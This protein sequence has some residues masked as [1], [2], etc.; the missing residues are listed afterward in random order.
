MI[1][2]LNFNPPQPPHNKGDLYVASLV[3]WGVNIYSVCEGEDIPLEWHEEEFPPEWQVNYMIG[4]HS[5]LD[6]MK[7][8]VEQHA[9]EHIDE[10]AN[11]GWRKH[12]HAGG[13][14]EDLIYV[15]YVDGKVE[16]AIAI[17]VQKIGKMWF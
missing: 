1:R 2:P 14:D 8:L 7:K 15:C 13:S 16:L 9:K 12:E 4:H 10:K 6:I 17:L 5:N 3:A 11:W